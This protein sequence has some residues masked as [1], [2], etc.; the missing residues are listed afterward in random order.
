M[1]QTSV[2][3]AKSMFELEC[4]VAS[5]ELPNK[6][7]SYLHKLKK[8]DMIYSITNYNSYNDISDN[9]S[10]NYSNSS[11]KEFLMILNTQCMLENIVLYVMNNNAESYYIVWNPL[12][13]KKIS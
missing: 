9:I 4:L 8:Y 11:A 13:F 7:S 6:A 12:R 5:Y 10:M 2:K 3:F 1:K